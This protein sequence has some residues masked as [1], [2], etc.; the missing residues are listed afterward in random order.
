MLA[1]A[2]TQPDELAIVDIPEPTT[3]PYEIKIK[4]EVGYI[5]N[6]TDR[7]LIEGHFPGV[8]EF[9]FLLGHETAGIVAEVGGKVRNF[10]VGDRVIG[11]LLLNTTDPTYKSGWG[12]FSEYIIA[13]DHFAMIDDGV[14][15]EEHGWLDVYEVMRTIPKHISP[16][17][18]A[19][20]C[21]WREVYSGL[22]WDFH[23]KPGDD[24]LIY[25]DGPV[26]LSFVKFAR[27][28]GFGDIYLVGKYPGKLEKAREMGATGTLIAGSEELKNLV[29]ER[30]KPFDG[31]IDGVGKPDIINEAIP[32]V[33]MGGSVC[34]Y[35]VVSE[36]SIT[37]MHHRGPL[38]F[39]LLMHQWPTRDGERRAQEPL[40]DWIQSGKLSFEEFLSGEFSIKDISKA[41]EFSKTK[42]TVKTLLRF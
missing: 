14:A 39:N 31:V 35:G 15:S 30:G 12:G 11:G 1:T 37:L 34:V 26:G 20:L 38:N 40:V 29:A 25:G 10:N 27:L 23:L 33:R 3:G 4:T 9:P 19:M 32:Q 41:Y 5:C 21:M 22:L 2:V 28:L 16:E 13:G 7:K 17:D 24:I 8:D 18:G 6:A 36:E 42:E